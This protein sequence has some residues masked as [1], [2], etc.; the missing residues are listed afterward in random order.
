MENFPSPPYYLDPLFIRHQRVATKMSLSIGDDKDTIYTL[1]SPMKYLDVYLD[2]RLSFKEQQLCW[3][4][5]P[6]MVQAPNKM[7][8]CT[9]LWFQITRGAYYFSKIPPQPY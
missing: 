6:R 1:F 9:T 2:Y 7:H 3:Y 4:F 8:T 5:L